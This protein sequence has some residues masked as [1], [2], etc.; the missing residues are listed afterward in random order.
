[1]DGDQAIWMR[2]KP[3]L[4][5]IVTGVRGEPYLRFSPAGVAVNTRSA[6]WFLNRVYPRAVPRSVTLDAARVEAADL[7]SLVDVA[8]RSSSHARPVGASGG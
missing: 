7:A 4:T 2:A 5:V 6:T 3:S 1:M 8:R